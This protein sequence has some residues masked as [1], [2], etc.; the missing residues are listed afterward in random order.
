MP[1][2]SLA[3]WIGTLGLRAPCQLAWQH[4]ASCLNLTVSRWQSAASDCCA[5]WLLVPSSRMGDTSGASPGRSPFC[6]AFLG[7]QATRSLVAP[8]SGV[9][10]RHMCN[11]WSWCWEVLFC[12]RQNEMSCVD[13]GVVS[14]PECCLA[15]APL[16]EDQLVGL[17]KCAGS[18]GHRDPGR[19]Q[20]GTCARYWVAGAQLLP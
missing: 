3:C 15:S 5:P 14:L 20:R 4:E 8:N 12:A 11:K 7:V 16:L 18:G 1:M 6:R 10:Q 2:C 19:E 9:M 13:Y 17:L